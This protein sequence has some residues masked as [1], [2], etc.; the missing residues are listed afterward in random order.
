MKNKNILKIVFLMLQLL[1]FQSV[2]AQTT[3]NCPEIAPFLCNNGS[4]TNDAALCNQSW[5]GG[6]NGGVN[7]PPTSTNPNG[8]VPTTPSIDSTRCSGNL[9]YD[10]AAARECARLAELQGRA[11]G[12]NITCNTE[13]INETIVVNA[14]PT[15]SQ[16]TFSSNCTINGVPGFAAQNLVGY[17]GAG[18]GFSV[19]D[20]FY[21]S[22]TVYGS[23][24]NL[25]P[26]WYSVPC[27][28]VDATSGRTGTLVG[29]TTCASGARSFFG[30]TNVASWGTQRQNAGAGITPIPIRNTNT[31][32]TIIQLINNILAKFKRLYGQQSIVN[33]NPTNPNNPQNPNNNFQFITNKATY[34][35]GENALYTISG[36]QSLVGSKITWTSTK[37]GNPTLELNSDYGHTL[38]SQNG[39]S[40]WT[41]Y[42]YT[43]KTEDVGNWSKTAKINNVSRISNFEVRACPATTAV[44]CAPRNT[45]WFALFSTIPNLVASGGNGNYTWSAPGSTKESGAGP[46]FSTSYAQTGKY[47]ITVSS[48]GASGTC[49]VNI[50]GI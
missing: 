14:N 16:Q 43:W 30:N 41:D 12:Y 48:G 40:F 1:I 39:G 2:G 27:S 42:S 11:Q 37:N 22:T 23:G 13:T 10:V 24:F 32:N 25:N 3:N 47:T 29:A 9:R 28:L 7:Q 38:W 18:P 8:N 50:G 15:G 5:G 26:M 6:L 44:S 20:P 46:Q 21:G 17:T 49:E 36:N 35:V 45:T 4:C 34:C 31:P 19:Y 33:T